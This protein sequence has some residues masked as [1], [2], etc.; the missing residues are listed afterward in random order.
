MMTSITVKRRTTIEE[1]FECEIRETCSSQVD[2]LVVKKKKFSFPTWIWK[3]LEVL[4]AG[5]LLY[6][7][8]ST[9]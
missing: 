8:K 7:K 2:E 1:S 3:G 5:V 6:L 4:F 9:N